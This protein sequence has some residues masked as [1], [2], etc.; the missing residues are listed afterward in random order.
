L[1]PAWASQDP[2]SKKKKKSYK[3]TGEVAQGVD[4][5]FKPQYH[6]KK[7]K[8][9]RKENGRKKFQTVSFINFFFW[10]LFYRQKVGRKLMGKI[11]TNRQQLQQKQI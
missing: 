2:F 5:E 10:Y 4:P 3:R 11:R 9:E 7:K 8:K 1:K 6:K